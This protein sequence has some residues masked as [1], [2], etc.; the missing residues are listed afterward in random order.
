MQANP[1]VC[2][3]LLLAG[4]AASGQERAVNVR[5]ADAQANAAVAAGP[6]GLVVV[7]SSHYSSAGRSN[8]IIAR[9]LDPNGE[10]L[11]DEFQVNPTNEGNQTKPS[12]AMSGQ[13]DFV[14][15]WQGPG[16]DQNDV[17]VRLYD[18]NGQPR[19]EELLANEDT[20]GQQLRPRLAIG[21][22]GA[23]IVVW[24]DQVDK[25]YSVRGRL[26][27]SS[28]SPLGPSLRL[29]EGAGDARYPDIAMDG[30]GNLA[31]VWLQ[32]RSSNTVFAR[33][34]DLNGV[35]R[36]AAFEVSTSSF[37]SVTGPSIAMNGAG[38]FVI[39]WDGDP[40]RASDDDV[41]GRC[42]DPNGRPK[43]EP[44]RVNALREGAEQWPQVA[45][46]DANEF[47]VVWQ[48]DTQDPNEATD[49]FGQRFDGSGNPAGEPLQLNTYT[50]GHQ[51]YP[52]VALMPNGAF[53]AVWESEGQDGSD[54]GIRACVEA[55]KSNIKDQISKLPIK[56]QKG[57]RE[58]IPH[59]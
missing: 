14:I 34:F 20:H 28:G 17:F 29:D 13:G 44:F 23:F 5:T 46:N 7:W 53:A 56:N 39:V 42:Y 16:A 1:F 6:Q 19:S 40:N 38:D 4:V 21:E 37:S 3:I 59:F 33:L 48:H 54:Y 57:Y 10:P 50:A 18:P 35:P 55:G 43:G 26:F 49:V 22:G 24:E 41:L 47:V 36:T 9:R 51:R 31:A 12:V 8:E 2:A 25:F 45:I 32:D 11:G 58:A 52:D 15:A 30:R 27:D